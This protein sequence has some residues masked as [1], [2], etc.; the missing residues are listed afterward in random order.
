MT[1]PLRPGDLVRHRG[2]GDYPYLE[3]HYG[4]V[5]VAHGTFGVEWDTERPAKSWKTGGRG[6]GHDIDDDL[7]MTGARAHCGWYVAAEDVERV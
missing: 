4:I 5:Q 1:R 2:T 6:Y 7:H 3:G